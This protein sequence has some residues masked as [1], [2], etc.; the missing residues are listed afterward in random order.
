MFK[1]LRKSMLYILL[2][3]YAF[4]AL[5]T[6]SNQAVLWAN[7]DTFPVMINPI[8]AYDWSHKG[9]KAHIIPVEAHPDFPHGAVFIN[10]NMH[11]IMTPHTHLNAL[12][13]IFDF[14]DTIYSVGDFLLEFGDWLSAFTPLV[15]AGALGRKLFAE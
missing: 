8:K 15:W 1:F 13:D 7:H 11:V 9:T 6:L 2:A 4:G 14:H 3:P 10:D 5:G 12:A